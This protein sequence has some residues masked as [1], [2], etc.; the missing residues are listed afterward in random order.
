MAEAAHFADAV[1]SQEMPEGLPQ[2]HRCAESG[3]MWLTQGDL[4]SACG[5]TT[6]NISQIIRGVYDR[7]RLCRQTTCRHLLRVQVEGGRRVRRRLKC[8]RMDLV[9][10]VVERVQ[11]PKGME[12]CRWVRSMLDGACR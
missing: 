3:T 8:Y 1:A 10:A 7:G 2:L 6:Q 9:L 5:T 11:S 4:A 12:F